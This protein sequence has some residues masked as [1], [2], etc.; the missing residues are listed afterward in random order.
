MSAR[1]RY[2]AYR[3]AIATVAGSQRKERSVMKIKRLL[4]LVMSLIVVLS[5]F[6]GCV[7]LKHEHLTG[8]WRCD[9][10]AHWR[11]ITCNLERCE[12][13][14]SKQP[15]VDEDANRI[16]DV[17]GYGYSRSRQRSVLLKDSDIHSV[18]VS[19]YPKEYSYSFSG[20]DV[21]EFT[22][23]LFGLTLDADLEDNP[24]DYFGVTWVI[25]LEYDNGETSSLYHFGNKF[26]RSDDSRWYEMT[27][28]EASKLE[29]LLNRAS[30]FE[31][32]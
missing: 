20:D 27:D 8:E 4:S 30:A 13:E 26:I 32:I 6:C 7:L 2:P 10:N 11:S 3:L 29:D 18:T 5:C 21:N 24:N 17:C 16:C 25:L 19:S 22:D 31:I 23:Y 12:I 1:F 9:E 28:D 14:P 15:H